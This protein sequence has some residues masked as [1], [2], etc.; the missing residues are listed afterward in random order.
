[1]LLWKTM[2]A[3]MKKILFFLLLLPLFSAAQSDKLLYGYAYGM[4]HDGKGGGGAIA[5]VS[6]LNNII[7]VGPGVEITSYSDHVLIPVFADL[8]IKHRFTNIDPY[9]TGQFGRNG[10]NVSRTTDIP[11]AGGG[12]QRITFN[13]S[14]KYFYGIGAGA[15][16]HFP[17]I[18]VFVSYIYRG[19]TY[20]YPGQVETDGQVTFRDKSVNANVFIA[21]IVF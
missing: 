2:S 9:I 16:W 21:G 19:Y 11:A 7:G 20:R 14:G 15:A 13:E 8:K 18:G 3:A 12:Q 1:M 5:N 17:K 4:V 6:L 10:Y